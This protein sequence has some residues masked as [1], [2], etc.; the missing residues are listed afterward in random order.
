M[1][2]RPTLDSLINVYR[3][4]VA[5]NR[6]AEVELELRLLQRDFGLFAA[7]HK[8]LVAR[9]G[10]TVHRLLSVLESGPRRSEARVASRIRE[11]EFVGPAGR[12]EQRCYTKRQ[13]VALAVEG[14]LPYRIALSV[15]RP[16]PCGFV[17]GADSLV[18]LKLRSSFPLTVP[19][20]GGAFAWR[21]DATVV[22]QMAGGA[23]A[24][25]LEAAAALMLRPERAPAEVLAALGL[26]GDDVAARAALYSFEL[27]LEFEGP[28]EL[29]DLLRPA[30]VAAA[31]RALAGLAG[32]APRAAAA[33][34]AETMRIAR[35]VVDSPARLRELERA[36]SLKQLLPQVR[37]ITRGDYRKLYP[38]R[39][40]YLTA[41]ADGKRA[42]ALAQDG[43]ARVV[44]DRL[45]AFAGAERAAREGETV[46]DGEL[47]EAPAGPAF[48][49]FDVIAVAGESVAGEGFERRLARLPEAVGRLRAGGVPAVA[50][51]FAHLA[52]ETPA[53]LEREIRGVLEA[54]QAFQADGL[55]FVEPGRPYAAT[56]SSKWKGLEHTSLDCLARRAPQAARGAPPFADRPGH[57]LHFLFVTIDEGLY[58]ALGLQ[59]CPGYAE[60]FGPRPARAR[61]PRAPRAG[62]FPIQFAPCDA[63][64][65]YLY[66]HPD[67]SPLGEVDGR[68]L[69]VR[70]AGACAAAGG[71]APLAD[72]EAMRLRADRQAELEAGRYFGN[73]YL[74]AETTWLNYVDPFPLEQLW[75]GPSDDYFLRPK[76][77]PYGA[78]TAALSF[79]KDQRIAQLGGAAWVV[80]LGAG[81]GQD[82]HRFRAAGVHRLVVVDKSRAA[83]AEL[84]RRNYALA[85]GGPARPARRMTLYALAAD[86]TQPAAGLLERLRAL[87]VPAEGADALVC[88]LAV[89]YFL[90]S[91]EGLG[92]FA[93]LAR[94]A[95]RPGGQLVLTIL[96]GDAVHAAF[97]AA[98]LG[99]GQAWEAREKGALKYSLQ[100]LYAGDELE[101]AGQR[102]GVLLPFSDG[103]HY[104]EPL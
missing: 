54:P 1:A 42:V 53:E 74:V 45:L 25:A 79:L 26:E 30:D 21:A 99:P 34:Q 88:N 58:A 9:G 14:D 71:G 82:L 49:A 67:A 6:D 56:C 12:K 36:C 76:A 16:E 18:R 33:L 32:A 104:E 75:A 10:G 11:Y 60:L 28:P 24:E 81:K 64:L 94:G 96:R 77:A 70:C 73:H 38:P 37:A 90:G 95:V 91:A 102:I 46:V 3:R 62:V 48:Y 43:R 55:I 51:S 86:A 100:R 78:Q 15:E 29:R 23:A 61:S 7:I 57:R 93:E 83:L 50:K 4:E 84:V 69:E 31:E 17:A 20:E 66:Q 8:A 22:R 68:V 2:A 85:R 47:V 35:H 80:D 19:G 59:L 39:G 87:G 40:L 92:N 5:G 98:G 101:A 13:L 52:G 89:H 41:K 72:W 44:A 65:A 103:R 63:P 27:E 97:T